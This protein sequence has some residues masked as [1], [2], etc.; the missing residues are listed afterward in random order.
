MT[1]I[2]AAMVVGG[3]GTTWASE[4]IQLQ[5]RWHTPTAVVAHVLGDHKGIE[6][7]LPLTPEMG[8]DPVFG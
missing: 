8:R 6:G 4:V 3:S 5:Q 2:S 1:D 7:F